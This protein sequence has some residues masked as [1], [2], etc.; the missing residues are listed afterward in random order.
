MKKAGKVEN[1]GEIQDMPN[2]LLR[3]MIA[4]QELLAK[5]RLC[6][7]QDTRL[8]LSTKEYLSF[9]CNKI[10]VSIVIFP[11]TLHEFIHVCIQLTRSSE[12]CN[13]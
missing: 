7:I 10:V 3:N 4:I 6:R 9:L 12:L 11:S 5:S 2:F 1:Q 13:M 8:L